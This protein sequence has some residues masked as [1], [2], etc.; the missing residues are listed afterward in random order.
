MFEK[1]KFVFIYG[2]NIVIKCLKC[3]LP[4]VRNYTHYTAWCMSKD[5]NL[6]INVKCENK[7]CY[8]NYYYT[9]IW[10]PQHQKYLP[11]MVIVRC[12]HANK[13]NWKM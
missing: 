2:Q 11:G 7:Q 5:G 10:S 3:P 13:K 9:V 4:T 8:K 6:L 12:I 1:C